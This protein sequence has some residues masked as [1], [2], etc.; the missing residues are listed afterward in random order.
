ML[1]VA[2]QLGTRDVKEFFNAT[3][4]LADHDAIQK[5]MAEDGYIF[6]KSVVDPEIL[7]ALR[8]QITA[9]CER[10][11]WMESNQDHRKCISDHTPVVESDEAYLPIYS[12]IQRL[13]SFH[14]LAHEPAIMNAMRAVVGET[15]FP[16]PLSICRLVFPDNHAWATPAHQDFPNNQ[17]TQ[18]LYASW[19]PL[20]ECPQTSGSL[21]ILRGSNKLGLLPLEYSLG[22]GHRRCIFDQ[23][24]EQLDW[25]SS[26]LE[27]G[28]MLIFHSLTVH[29]S[30][31]NQ[32]AAMRIS[33][34]YRF[35]QEGESMSR[36][37]LRPHFSP[38]SWERIYRDWQRPELQYY[39][40]GK[41]V[42]YQD[43][44]ADIHALPGEHFKEAL[45]TKGAYDKQRFS[46]PD[47]TN[48]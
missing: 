18:D 22:A 25:V 2:Q 15:A 11:G 12:E 34:D 29:K 23:R 7:L 14:G 31:E 21:A 47:Q 32:S 42:I 39:W 16:H 5:K 38:D 26:D 6:L 30:L 1:D 28:D 20:V 43:W 9:I 40:R 41:H 35:Q 33:V 3:P 13:E 44:D 36:A 17:G 48:Q 46:S 19:I 24:H 45:R 8:H 10:H 4:L 37:C 27:L